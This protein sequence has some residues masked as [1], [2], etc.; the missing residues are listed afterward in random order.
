MQGPELEQGE[1][2]RMKSIPEPFLRYTLGSL[3]A[4]GALNA[5]GGG[6]YGLMGAKDVPRE[7]LEGTPFQTY[8]IPSLILF[9]VV[10]GSFLVAALAVFT[11]RPVA[12][13]AATFAGVVVLG[14]IAVQVAMIGYV[15]WMQPVTFLV[16]SVILLL[17][18]LAP[19]RRRFTT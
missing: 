6:Y 3:L 1:S 10:G 13:I 8:F 15:S 12:K 18:L 7:W 11:R 19:S 4:F 16:G 9:F 2:T 17:A 14:W 5:F